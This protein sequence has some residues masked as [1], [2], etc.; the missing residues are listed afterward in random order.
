LLEELRARN[1]L[2]L[3]F[4]THDIALAWR[5]CDRII[6]LDNGSVVEDAPADQLV[7]KPRAAAS[8]MLVTAQFGEFVKT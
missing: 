1:N 4:I 8:K 2:S 6:V 7:K 5:L 3:L